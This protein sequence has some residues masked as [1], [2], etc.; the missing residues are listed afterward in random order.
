MHEERQN[1]FFCNLNQ[2]SRATGI[3]I[4]LAVYLEHSLVLALMIEPFQPDCVSNLGVYIHI[5][6]YCNGC[7]SYADIT[8]PL[9]LITNCVSSTTFHILKDL[10]RPPVVT[11]LSLDRL[12]I[13]VTPSW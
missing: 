2:C 10:S 3:G 11:A 4:M 5:Y 6:T 8:H 7:K 1:T 13:P 12:S 9:T